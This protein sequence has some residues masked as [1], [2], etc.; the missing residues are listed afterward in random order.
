MRVVNVYN[1]C[2]PPLTV[3]LSLHHLSNPE[4]HHR[5]HGVLLQVLPVQ[6]QNKTEVCYY[7]KRAGNLMNS[8]LLG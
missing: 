6:I 4:L 7:S 2:D 1:L 3:P 5:S 8:V